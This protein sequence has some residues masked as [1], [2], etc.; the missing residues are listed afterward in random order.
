MRELVS[1]SKVYVE[2]MYR[3]RTWQVRFAASTTFIRPL[4][5]G[6]PSVIGTVNHHLGH[7]PCCFRIPCDRGHAYAGNIANCIYLGVGRPYSV[8]DKRADFGYIRLNMSPSLLEAVQRGLKIS[9]GA[10]GACQ[11]QWSQLLRRGK[12]PRGYEAE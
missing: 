10:P 6:K 9:Q 12:G 2:R 7:C 4:R 1:L 3:P 8:I 11:V 5:D